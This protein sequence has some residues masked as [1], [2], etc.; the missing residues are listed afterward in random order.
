[1]GMGSSRHNGKLTRVVPSSL[2]EQ[3]HPGVV[4]RHAFEHRRR[5]QH[6]RQPAQRALPSDHTACRCCRAGGAPPGMALWLTG[7]AKCFGPRTPNAQE[8]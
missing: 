4:L 7:L 6:T 8:Q 5:P 1:M 2:P 3:L